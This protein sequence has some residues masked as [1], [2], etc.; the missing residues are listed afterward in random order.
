MFLIQDHST[1]PNSVHLLC[2]FLGPGLSLE[3]LG[4]VDFQGHVKVHK[5][6]TMSF[7]HLSV[8][9]TSMHRY[10]PNLSVAAM[11]QVGLRLGGRW[12]FVV[13]TF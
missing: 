5:R 3:G 7:G 9:G 4:I 6:E 12:R 8:T 13:L 2:A 1:S 11:I 10:E